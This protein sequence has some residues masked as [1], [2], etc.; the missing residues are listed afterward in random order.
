MSVDKKA[1]LL[2]RLQVAYEELERVLLEVGEEKLAEPGVIGVWS[3]KDILAH[4]TAWEGRVV[5]WIEALKHGGTPRPAPWS[6]D[7]SEEQ[8]NAFIYEQNKARPFSEVVESWRKTHRFV[9]GFIRESSE[10]DLFTR[11]IDW[12]GSQPFADAIPG[13]TYEHQHEHAQQIRAWL[14]AQKAI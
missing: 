3:V 13:N 6:K 1:E 9:A 4:V 7:L 11:K 10:A 2:D 5:A 12:L 8:V 14:A